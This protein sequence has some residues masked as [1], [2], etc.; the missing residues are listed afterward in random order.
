MFSA[1]RAGERGGAAHEGR[2]RRERSKNACV[3]DVD[4]SLLRGVRW[5]RA[6]ASA[7]RGPRARAAEPG[8]R[9]S[10]AGPARRR[11]R[12]TARI[13]SSG[14]PSTSASAAADRDRRKTARPRQ[15][16]P[17]AAGRAA[18]ETQSGHT[19]TIAQEAPDSSSDTLA[20]VERRT[21]RAGRG[22][23][24]LRKTAGR[25][26]R[27]QLA[28]GREDRWPHF[29]VTRVCPGGGHNQSAAPGAAE[30]QTIPPVRPGRPQM[31]ARELS[32]QAVGRSERARG[33][34]AVAPTTEQ[35]EEIRGVQKRWG[36]EKAALARA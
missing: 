24:D 33:A 8:D 10:D 3:R 6:R 27:L 9:R 2:C 11:S 15:G 32:L 7:G 13:P 20:L 35:G 28:A 23:A 25:V 17:A 18:R 26:Q 36:K 14:T 30:A 29:P 34:A 1:G 12:D 5:R 21:S 16:L 22:A 31:R 19:E 4:Q